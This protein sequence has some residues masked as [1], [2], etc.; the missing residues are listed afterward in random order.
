MAREA[1]GNAAPKVRK[2]PERE[3]PKLAAVIPWIEEMLQADQK[4]PRKQR[5][6]V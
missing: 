2:V 1:I 5:H 4:A 6:T 3:K